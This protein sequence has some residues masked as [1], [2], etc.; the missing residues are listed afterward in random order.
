[1]T[2]SAELDRSLPA[3]HRGRA[4]VFYD[5]VCGM[6]HRLVTL[7]MRADRRGRV[8]YAPL[9]GAR[10]QERVAPHGVDPSRLDTFV[11]LTDYG[12]PSERIWVR[13][14]AA[15]ELAR[16]L[17]GVYRPLSWLRILPRGLTD[18]AYRLV[19]AYR[20]RIFGKYETCRVP[21]AD[22][23]ARHIDLA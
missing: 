1:M 16:I 2:H 11:L 3:E 18:A 14:A 15:F 5:G 20:Y 8:L 7:T 17:G 4:V 10:A 22:E 6:C 19:A 12:L 9:Q 23:R 21:T 13:S